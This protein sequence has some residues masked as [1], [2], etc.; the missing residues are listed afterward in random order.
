MG[1]LEPLSKASDDYD[2]C[3]HKEAELS[4]MAEGVGPYLAREE[5]KILREELEKCGRKM[6]DLDSRLSALN[7][8]SSHLTDEIDNKKKEMWENGGARLEGAKK[9]LAGY[10]KDL[11]M[12]SQRA[13]EYRVLADILGLAVPASLDEFIKRRQELTDL[14]S[15]LQKKYDRLDG[16]KSAADSKEREIVGKIAQDRMELDSLR[17][18]DS[19]IP[20][21]FISIRK[22][23]ASDLLVPE[24][25]MPFAGEIM[26]VKPEESKWEGALERLLSEF[27]VSMLVPESL[28]ERVITWMEHH[29]LRQRIVYYRVEE[30]TSPIDMRGLPGKSAARKLNI[31]KDSPYASWLAAELYHRFDHICAESTADF[32]KASFA[33]SPEGQIK[34]QG[35]WHKKDD[36][37]PIDDRRHYVLGFSN[38]EKIVLISREL[39][40][41]TRD[42]EEARKN[43]ESVKEE[44][45]Q[46]NNRRNVAG[47]LLS[48]NNFKDMD[49]QSFEERVKRQEEL[50]RSLTGHDNILARLE[51]EIK[52]LQISWKEMQKSINDIQNEKGRLSGVIAMHEEKKRADEN[53]LSRA[54]ELIRMKAFKLLEQHQA[55]IIG[56]NGRFTLKSMQDKNGDYNRWIRK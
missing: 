45:D 22:Q 19:N 40:R 44:R 7:D 38:K 26:E 5:I 24:S 10:E 8:E 25:D 47:R 13:E 52:K 2:S 6:G 37:Y 49:K 35:K 23:L 33:L 18:R 21:R 54:S 34:A 51:G 29:F 41:L 3:L 12:V 56:K 14:A 53:T 4:L 42:R 9:D 55:D 46:C 1:I 15:K 50:I 31:K 27:G 30:Y 11:K 36:R 28:Y 17:K 16:E 32:K 39:D 48:F 20:E 43:I